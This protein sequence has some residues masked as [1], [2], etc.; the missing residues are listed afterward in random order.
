MIS[1]LESLGAGSLGIEHLPSKFSAD[2]VALQQTSE[3][4]FGAAIDHYHTVQ[5]VIAPFFC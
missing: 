2:L 1:N 3:L 5:K 4:E